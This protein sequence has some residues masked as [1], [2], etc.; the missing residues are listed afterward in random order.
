[1][2]I[3]MNDFNGSLFDELRRLER[4]VSPSVSHWPSYIRAPDSGAYP[5]I[6]VGSTADQLDVYAFLPGVVASDLDISIQQNLL[7]IA[8]E[9]RLIGEEGADYFRKERFDGPFRRILSLPEDVDPDR[10][11]AQYQDGVLHIRI[12][13]RDSA[14]PRQIQV[15]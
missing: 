3:N 4:M 13:R 5:P 1:M 6:N 9:R 2:F 11:D 12:Q 14:K 15:K 8:G 7:T 10:L